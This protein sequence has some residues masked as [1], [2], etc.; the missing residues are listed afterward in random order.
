MDIRPQDSRRI[1]IM[2]HTKRLNTRTVSKNSHL[3]IEDLEDIEV[4]LNQGLNFKEIAYHLRRDPSTISKEVSRN[5]IRQ[6]PALFNDTKNNCLSAKTCKKQHICEKRDC[7]KFC[8]TCSCND[9]CPDFTP[10]VCRKHIRAPYVCNGCRDKKRCPADRYF[11]RAMTA[12]KRY[13]ETLVSSRQGINATPDQIACLNELLTPL[14]RRNQSVNHIYGSHRKELGISKST[15]YTYC[16]LS[17]FTFRNIDL[18][19]K[20]R[21]KPRRKARKAVLDQSHLVGRKYSDFKE[22]MEMNTDTAVVEM[23]VVETIKGERVFLTFFFRKTK[24]MLAFIMENQNQKCVSEV[25]D[26]L[27]NLFGLGVFQ[28]LFPVILT[29]NGGEFKHANTIE[30]SLSGERRSSVYYCDPMA[31]YQKGAL[32]KNHEFIRE[33]IPKSTSIKFCTPELTTLMINHINSIKRESINEK[34]PYDLAEFLMPS[35]TLE[36]LGLQRI[37]PDLVTRNPSIF[38]Q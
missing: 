21:Y 7:R 10:F 20:V 2:T 1:F 26:Y 28:T 29:D 33:Y 4:G 5:R 22:F 30:H 25:L 31:S 37:H 27:E 18:Q 14:I 23:D 17:L 6:E 35:I 16:D 19:R 34:T 32:E 15:F 12:Q 38:K 8:R 36:L 11:Y 9:L 13:Q 24:L 3:K